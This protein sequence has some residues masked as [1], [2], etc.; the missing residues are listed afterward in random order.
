M[1]MKRSLMI[2]S[3]PLGM[4][5]YIAIA[6][7]TGFCPACQSIVQSVTGANVELA[8]AEPSDHAGAQNSSDHAHQD[9]DDA[10]KKT[11]DADNHR[12][13]AHARPDENTFKQVR[14][15]GSVDVE[16][17]YDV[18]NALIP[19]DEIH[20]LLPRDAIPSLTDPKLE[21]AAGI[22]WLSPEDRVIV[23][24]VGDEV[25]AAPF[26]I[27]NFHEIVNMTVGGKPV[28]ATYC[29]LCDSATLVSRTLKYTDGHGHPAQKTIELGVSGALYNSNVLMYDRTDL[30][31][32]SQLGMRAVSGPHAG[33][34]LEHLPIRVIPFERFQFDYPKGKV[35]SIDTGHDKPY[36][37]AAYKSYFERDDLLVPVRGIGTALKAKKTLGV[38]ILAG[39]E[40]IFVTASAIGEQR[41]I[42]TAIGDIVL[43]TGENGVE[44]LSAPDGAQTA[45][46]FYYSWSAFHPET[47]VIAGPGE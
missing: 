42:R 18:T 33:T 1:S 7:S 39:D 6:G 35:V 28:A 13:P 31:L 27:L 29:P 41:T 22:D 17:E 2:A 8:S 19:L 4:A 46:T 21:D 37:M 12:D 47:R 32:W 25:V 26:R 15:P 34:V 30:A 11:A 45:Q 43:R 5:A 20:A 9:Q 10:H 16:A 44:V 14:R 23:V 36:G 3:I 40:A 38:G 24:Q